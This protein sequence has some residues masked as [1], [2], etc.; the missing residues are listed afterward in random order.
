MSLIVYKLQN[1]QTRGKRMTAR[2]PACAEIGADKK[3]EH[4]VI[5]D[6]GQFGCV[7]YPGHSPAARDHRGRIFALCGDRRIKPLI[8]QR[9]EGGSTPGRL[10]R[11]FQ[12]HHPGEPIKTGLLGRL[13]RAFESRSEVG[14]INHGILPV[15]KQTETETGVLPVLNPLETPNRQLTAQELSVLGRAAMENDPLVIMAINLFNGT[16]VER[17]A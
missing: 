11:P 5:N 8:I 6:Q 1:V 13:G 17:D 2:C 10:G 16:I 3:G 14:K 12:S 15:E 7:V 4:L 9:A